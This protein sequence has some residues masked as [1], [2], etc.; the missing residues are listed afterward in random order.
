MGGQTG[1]ES[2]RR[3]SEVVLGE[4][5]GGFPGGIEADSVTGGVERGVGDSDG[6]DGGAEK[7]AATAEEVEVGGVEEVGPA[8]ADE[9]DGAEG[10]MG[11][12]REAFEEEVVWEGGDSGFA[13]AVEEG[14]GG[15][16]GG[17]VA[18]GVVVVVWIWVAGFHE[19]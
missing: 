3:G 17:T 10:G 11:D 9:G 1:E 14:G 8:A 19:P 18:M 12:S 13:V 4:E 2:R 5:R 6:E 16:G 15:G 7:E